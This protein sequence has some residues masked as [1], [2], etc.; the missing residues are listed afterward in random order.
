MFTHQ[1]PIQAQQ[2]KVELM[3]RRNYATSSTMQTVL[4]MECT[5][6]LHHKPRFPAKFHS[7]S[8]QAEQ[9]A[10]LSQKNHAVS[11]II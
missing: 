11:L 4:H 1:E 6:S 9:E 3:R 7:Q 2:R 10:Q 8:R 5:P